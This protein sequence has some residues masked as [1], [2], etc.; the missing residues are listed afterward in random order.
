MA[1][2]KISKSNC[3]NYLIED[4]K[5]DA[6]IIIL[7]LCSAITNEKFSLKKLKT[8]LIKALDE[9][10]KTNPSK[11]YISLFGLASLCARIKMF[12]ASTECKNLLAAAINDIKTTVQVVTRFNL[13]QQLTPEFILDFKKTQLEKGIHPFEQLSLL[14]TENNILFIQEQV[15]NLLEL[16]GYSRIQL[17]SYMDQHIDIIDFIPYELLKYMPVQTNENLYAYKQMEKLFYAE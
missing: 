7:H 12:Y 6:K 15:I 10:V 13:K 5:D 16:M 4:Y 11:I 3:F 17:V 2:I 1:K 8:P 9:Y 14:D